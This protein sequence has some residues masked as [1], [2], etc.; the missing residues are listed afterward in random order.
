MDRSSALAVVEREAA[1]ILAIAGDADL[2]APVPSCPRWSLGELLEHLGR[3]Y[4]MVATALEGGPEQPIARD[5]IPRRQEG[6]APADWLAERLG[7]LLGLLRSVPETA[8][9][10][11]FVDGAGGPVAFWWRRQAHETLIHRV[12]AEL[13]A[14]VAGAGP[15]PT[16]AADGLQDFL[17]VQGLR[18]VP[19]D[20]IHLGDGLSVHLHATD[21]GVEAEWT[22]DVENRTYA[23]AHL[24]ADVA[25]RGPAWALDRW[26]WGRDAAVDAGELEIFGDG[27]AAAAWRAAL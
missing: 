20:E 11:N 6:Q 13:A 3:V 25:V 14:G 1:R 15:E 24:K 18:L 2:A 5:R 22:V 10:W 17:V 21:S 23:A 8:R 27:A 4:A 9:C 12:D 16:V 26:C 7:I 19:W